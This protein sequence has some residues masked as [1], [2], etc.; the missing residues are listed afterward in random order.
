LL[1][2]NVIIQIHKPYVIILF[3]AGIICGVAQQ[4][5]QANV[6]VKE[7]NLERNV[8]PGLD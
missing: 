7:G 6:W 8:F 3:C 1:S 4:D 2:E 5:A